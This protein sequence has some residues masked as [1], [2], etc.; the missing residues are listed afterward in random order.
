MEPQIYE[1]VYCKKIRKLSIS[2]ASV[3]IKVTLVDTRS[4][5][6]ISMKV[7]SIL[8]IFDPIDVDIVF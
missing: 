1:C 4:G 7:I 6:S 2:R 8:S 3:S 5:V